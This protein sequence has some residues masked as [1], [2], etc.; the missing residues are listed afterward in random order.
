MLLHI[1]HTTQYAYDQPVDYALQ[2]LRLTPQV[3]GCQRIVDWKITVDGGAVE[4]SYTDHH[5]N[6]V[7]LI[8]V[9]AGGVSVSITAAGSVE[10]TDTAG[11][12]PLPKNGPPLWYFSQTTALTT[13]GPAIEKLADEIAG[14]ANNLDRL[15]NLSRLIAKRVK[16]GTEG[17]YVATTAEEAVQ[18]GVGVCQ[19]HAHIF[20]TAA[21]AGGT[22][23]RYVSGYLMMDGQVDQDASHAWAEA[24][25]E[26]L[27]WVGFD[28]SNTQ[29]PDER[30]VRLAVGRDYHDAAP[31]SGMRVGNAK[32]TMIVNLQVQQ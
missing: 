15:H 20:I 25:V 2:Q 1:S 9:D 6:D 18:G 3:A 8:N 16:Y 10:T 4:A 29:S 24:Y 28:I 22:P 32:E 21:R 17:T 5:G 11:I 14:E 31:F 19:D 26:G 30:Y 7:H 12:V 27:G 23:A 13:P